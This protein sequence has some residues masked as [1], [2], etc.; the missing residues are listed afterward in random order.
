M[1]TAT[2]AGPGAPDVRALSGLLFRD[3]QGAAHEHWRKVIRHELF[4]HRPH[5]SDEERQRLAYQ[6]LR[7][8]HEEVGRPARLARDPQ[9]L[10]ALHEWTALAD[11]ATATVAGI[12]Y[13]L[14]LGSL[15]DDDTGRDLEEFTALDRVGTFLCTE[16]AHGND[17]SALETTARYDRQRAEFVLHTPHERAQ[18]YMPNTSAAGGPKSG[19][20]AARLVVDDEDRGVFLFL[21]PLSDHE[22]PLPGITV[23]PL[24]PRVGSPVDHCTTSFDQV[25]L[26]RGALL[27]GPHGRLDEEGRFVSSVGNVRKRALHAIGRVTVGKLCMSASTLGGCRAALAIAVRYARFRTVSGPAAGTR[28]PLAAHRSHHTPLLRHTATA[29]A[30]TF[31][32]RATARHWVT[33]SADQRA[34]SERRVA[35]TKGWITWQ[36]RNI[37]TAGRERCGAAGLFPVNGLAEFQANVDGAITAEG[38]NLAIWCKAASEMVFGADLAPE[39]PPATGGESLT[40]PEFLRRLVAASERHSHATARGQLRSGKRGDTLGRWNNASTAALDMVESHAVGLASDAFAAARETLDRTR[41][42]AVLDDLHALFLL[43]RVTPRSG[44]LL[45]DGALTREQVGRLPSAQQTLVERLLPQLDAL[46]EAFG[47]P[48][49]HFTALPMLSDTAGEDG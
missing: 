37:V 49:E 3:G 15:L 12:H 47:I 21:C 45:A 33:H 14:F 34:A 22:G 39:A 25:R 11:G 13:N 32:H 23:E 10:A 5:A 7:A 42:R 26:P 43:D 24:P 38:D 19:V 46:T 36:G 18:K 28:I 30:M 16:R 29:Y 20:V 2:G 41:T 40:E 9:A 35:V 4:R 1:S 44:Q 27:E 17:V 6:R 48:E 31:L 8:V